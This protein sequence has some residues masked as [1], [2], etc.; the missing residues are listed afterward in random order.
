MTIEEI[1]STMRENRPLT[2][3][4]VIEIVDSIVKIRSDAYNEG[5][6][7]CVDE[8]GDRGTKE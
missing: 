6:Q 2:G 7:D 4:E 5:W 8:G 1:A 3:N